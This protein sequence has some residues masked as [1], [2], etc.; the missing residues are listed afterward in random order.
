MPLQYSIPE[1]QLNYKFAAPLEFGKAIREAV[2]SVRAG[3]NK[4]D[5]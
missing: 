4:Q 3:S 2:G 1:G 5:R